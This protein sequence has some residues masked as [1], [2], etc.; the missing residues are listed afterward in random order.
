MKNNTIKLVI[1]SVD[2]SEFTERENY[3]VNKKWQIAD[4]FTAY[5]GK[6]IIKR[7]GWNYNI[8]AKL[9]NIPDDIM[10]A[11][12]AALDNDTFAVT[13]TDPHSKSDDR[14]TSDT[15]DRS[16]STGGSVVCELDD[17]LR[18]NIF[19]N[20]DSQF[21]TAGSSGSSGEISGNCL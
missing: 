19:I 11:L 4:S 20:I 12:T 1:G 3:S 17:G 2:V 14:C 7:S 10:Y 18:W 13:F 5:D 21:H 8:R 15:F 16:E 9:E 6:K